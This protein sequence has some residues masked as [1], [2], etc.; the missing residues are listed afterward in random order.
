MKPSNSCSAPSLAN[1]GSAEIHRAMAHI[2][3]EMG[4]FKEAGR[5]T[6]SSPRSSRSYAM[7]WFNLAVCLERQGSWD[8]ASEAFHKP[9][10]WTRAT[11]TRTLAWACATFGW[12]IQVGAVLLRTLSRTVARSRDALFG[13]A[14]A[15]QS[16]GHTDD[17]SKLYQRILE[18]DPDSE[19]RS[20]T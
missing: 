7:G 20:P 4:D 16:L 9:V 19:G 10:P 18:R 8:D 1:E 17:A 15:L 2:Q 3:F 6:G 14:A 5:A 13:K 11:W 12:K